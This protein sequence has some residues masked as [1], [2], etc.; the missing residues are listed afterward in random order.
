MHNSSP[1]AHLD[2]VRRYYKNQLQ[3]DQ[4]QD[5]G[6]FNV[7]R[8]IVKALPHY[9]PTLAKESDQIGG[10]LTYNQSAINRFGSDVTAGSADEKLADGTYFSRYNEHKFAEQE[11]AH[12][13]ADVLSEAHDQQETLKH[14]VEILTVLTCVLFGIGWLLGIIGEWAKEATE[15]SPIFCIEIGSAVYSYKL[16]AP[17]GK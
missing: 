16:E 11:I 4:K 17:D 8:E 13:E 1:Q 12:F 5:V 10:Q 6:L 2:T 15:Q 14:K 3:T 7:D 9:R